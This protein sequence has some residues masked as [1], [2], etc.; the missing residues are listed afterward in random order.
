M[1]EPEF[2][3][4]GRGVHQWMGLAAEPAGWPTV[5]TYE[6]DYLDWRILEP[7]QGSYNL[8]RV[9]TVLAA[10]AAKGGRAGF[11]VMPFLP[12]QAARVPSYVPKQAGGAAGLE[13]L[14]VPDRLHQPH[15]GHRRRLRPGS[16]VV[17]RRLRRLR[18]VGR[19]GR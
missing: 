17:V 6:R 3:N 16:A 7:S 9:E 10:A 18:V 12:G 19:V 5:D 1:S 15:A 11:R 13:Q 14:D 2:G 8:S 4:A